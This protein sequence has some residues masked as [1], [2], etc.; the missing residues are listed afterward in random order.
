[1]SEVDELIG[2][3]FNMLTV[4]KYVGRSGK[5]NRLRYGWDD[6]SAVSVQPTIKLERKSS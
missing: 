6:V 1:M 5:N 3:K 4:S 2:K